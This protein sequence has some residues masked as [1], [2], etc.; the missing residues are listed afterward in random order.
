[1]SE[2]KRILKAPVLIIIGIVIVVYFIWDRTNKKQNPNEIS[3]SGTIEVTEVDISAKIPGRIEE[4]KCDEGSEV[5]KGDL[6]VVLAHNEL[7][8]QLNQVQA[9]LMGAKEQFKQAEAQFKNAE[10]NYSRAQNLFKSGSYSRQQFDIAETQY[11]VTNAQM[12]VTK[13]MVNQANAQ[14]RYIRSQIEN[15]YLNSP[16]DGVILQKNAEPGEIVSPGTAILTIGNIL[17]PW[18][19]IYVSTLQIGK[20]KLNDMAVIKIDTFPGKN[21]EGRVMNISSE[22]EFTP[23]NIQT[24]DERTRLVYAV[25]ISIENTNGELKPGMPADAVISV[26]DT[27]MPTARP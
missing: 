24:K 2:K 21:Y 23:K 17:K 9:S 27:K 14:V 8:A 19:K 3:G 5:G 26:K 6:I 4:I 13:E 22:A 12:N 15:A 10:E 1:M 11:K 20:I 16:I 18:I 25:K 7:N